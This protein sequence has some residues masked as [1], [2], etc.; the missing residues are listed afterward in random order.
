MRK[1]SAFIILACLTMAAISQVASAGGQDI[2]NSFEYEGNGVLL[3]V[4]SMAINGTDARE[5]RSMLDDEYGNDDGILT[6]AE[7]DFFV[8]VMIAQGL[9]HQNLFTLDD[10]GGRFARVNQTFDGITGPTNSTASFTTTSMTRF[11]YNVGS[12]EKHVF[13]FTYSPM[14]A[15]DSHS[16][17]S[18]NVPDGWE[19]TEVTGLKDQTLS[20][21]LKTVEGLAPSSVEIEIT[22]ENTGVV[23]MTIIYI[24]IIGAAIPIYIILYMAR[25]NRINKKKDEAGKD[26][27]A[28]KLVNATEVEDGKKVN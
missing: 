12:D 3:L 5:Y 16:N 24:L 15:S 10:I 2:E 21:D 22:F 8:Q 20:E 18:F 27:E 23:D 28:N 14:I 17:Y 26:E 1:I 6:D 13:S 7:V 9:Q 11:H 25:L 19:I 4:G